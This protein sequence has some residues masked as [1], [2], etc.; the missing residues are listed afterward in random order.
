MLLGLLQN[1]LRFSI[2]VTANPKAQ[3]IE[4]AS[5]IQVDDP[6]V[7]HDKRGLVIEDGSTLTHSG[8]E[9]G[10]G[11]IAARRF[12]ARE[13]IDPR[14]YTLDS[15]TEVYRRHPKIG[16]LLSFKVPMTR[17]RYKLQEIGSPTLDT[18]LSSV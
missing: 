13:I 15:I 2:V 17:V 5:P 8:M 7:I 14:P 1:R 10:A 18:L 3:I 12:G 11:T 9:F 6:S 16:R 4:A